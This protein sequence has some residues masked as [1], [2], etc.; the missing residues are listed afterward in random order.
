MHEK[1]L[2]CELISGASKHYATGILVKYDT[3]LGES[4]RSEEILSKNDLTR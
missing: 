3:Q 4:S 1:L 2:P